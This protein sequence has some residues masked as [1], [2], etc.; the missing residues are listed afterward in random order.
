MPPVKERSL[1]QWVAGFAALYQ[2]P[3]STR[4]PEHMWLAAMAHFGSVGEAIRQNDFLEIYNKSTH[5]ICWICSFMNKLMTTNELIFRLN[6]AP[7]TQVGFKYPHI[8][9]HCFGN[10]CVCRQNEREAEVEKVFRYRRWLAKLKK[11]EPESKNWSLRQWMNMYEDIYGA[12]TDLRSLDSIGFHLLEEGGEEAKAI[13]TLTQ[14]RSVSKLSNTG[15]SDRFLRSTCTLRGLIRHHNSLL[16]EMRIHTGCCTESDMRKKRLPRSYDTNPVVSKW[17]IVSAKIEMIAELGDTFSWLCTVLLKCND[18][19]KKLN[20][21]GNNSGMWNI[22]DRLSDIYKSKRPDEPLKCYACA[23]TH[24]KCVNY[25][26]DI[27]L[28]R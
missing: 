7:W 27:L 23:K 25:S 2:G 20:I 21:K 11:M 28:G 19:V 22:E 9:G 4:Y 12:K 18:I 5:A 16:R 6:E 1:A 26:G 14:F 24:C 17:R 8:C 3:D 10:K 13:R 15:I